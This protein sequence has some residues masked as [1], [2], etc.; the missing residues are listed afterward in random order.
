MSTMT[1]SE[2]HALANV[3]AYSYATEEADA[4]EN[5][6]EDDPRHVY[7]DLVILQTWLEA[8]AKKTA[9]RKIS[10]YQHCDRH[11]PWFTGGRRDTLEAMVEGGP[12]GWTPG[13]SG[14]TC[15]LWPGTDT[16]CATVCHGELDLD[17][18]TAPE[19][20]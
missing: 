13:C 17:W 11:A 10:K 3:V 18:T 19:Q 7:A 12:G 16:F 9:P 2:R 14:G 15:R 20:V 4:V 5:C 1:D 8:T 6:M